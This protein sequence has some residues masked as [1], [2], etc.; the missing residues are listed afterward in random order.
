VIDARQTKKLK[1]EY[2]CRCGARKCRGTMLAQPEKEKGA[3]KS[4]KAAKKAK[5]K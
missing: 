1:K 3:S 2:E 5:K 4:A